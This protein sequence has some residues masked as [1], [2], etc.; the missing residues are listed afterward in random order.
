[1]SLTSAHQVLPIAADADGTF[2]LRAVAPGS[3]NLRARD[4]RTAEA[5]APLELRIAAD[6]KLENIELRVDP[7][8]TVTGRVTSNGTPVPG[9]RINAYA[10]ASGHGEQRTAISDVDG[11]FKLQ[12][13][14]IA[15]D[16]LFI[17]AAP[18]RTLHS[19]RA[20]IDDR[21]IA[22]DVAPA[23]GTVELIASSPYRLMRDGVL[24]PDVELYS[25]IEAHG[26]AVTG[27]ERL[28]IPDLAPGH[29]AACTRGGKCTEGDLAPRGSL[30]LDIR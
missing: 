22:I 6:E 17:I 29:Y 2:R 8:H 11:V 1:V 28:T 10:I 5:S 24:L 14:A 23:G 13:A 19:M 15:K 3:I 20:M 26:I 30:T 18:G 16:A 4:R 25:W 7:L 27:G 12:L 9:A 21:P